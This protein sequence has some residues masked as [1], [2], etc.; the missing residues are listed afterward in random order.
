MRPKTP[1]RD[2]YGL[3][4]A[5][6]EARSRRWKNARLGWELLTAGA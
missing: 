3:A 5:G 1:L 6:D 4:C 2:L